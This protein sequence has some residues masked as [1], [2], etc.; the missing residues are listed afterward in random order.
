MNTHFS[1]IDPSDAEQMA[2]IDDFFK[3]YPSDAEDILRT[4]AAPYPPKPAKPSRKMISLRLPEATI[5]A[6]RTEAAQKGIGYQTLI[7]MVLREYANRHR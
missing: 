7:G 5:E 4:K 3:K 6:L 2:T 1:P